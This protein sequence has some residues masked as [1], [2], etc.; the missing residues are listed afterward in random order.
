MTASTDAV[1]NHACAFAGSASQPWGAGLPRGAVVVIWTPGHRSAFV[2]GVC[3]HAGTTRCDKLYIPAMH[4]AAALPFVLMLHGGNQSPEDF[5]AGTG[6]NARAGEQGFFV[7]Y[8]SK[9]LHQGAIH[10][11]FTTEQTPRFEGLTFLTSVSWHCPCERLG[12]FS[13]YFLKRD[14]HELQR[15][16]YLWHVQRPAEWRGRGCPA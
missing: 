5:A 2:D 14:E 9:L 11:A 13:T 3:E 16:R 10:A 4:E 6:M 7:L 12:Q 15:A 1:A 8:P